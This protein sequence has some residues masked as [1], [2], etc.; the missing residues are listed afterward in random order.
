MQEQA[1]KKYTLF[2][3]RIHL[4]YHAIRR[5]VECGLDPK[6]VEWFQ[7]IYDKDHGHQIVHMKVTIG[8]DTH[9]KS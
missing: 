8:F 1:H 6:M 9:E 3:L 2:S 7:Y 4:R 5:M